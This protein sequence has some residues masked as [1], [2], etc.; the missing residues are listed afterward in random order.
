MTEGKIFIK[1]EIHPLTRKS[2]GEE[3]Q[4][5]RKIWQQQTTKPITGTTGL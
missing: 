4:K 1:D 3:L 2:I 5:I